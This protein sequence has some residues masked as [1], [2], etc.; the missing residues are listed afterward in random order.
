MRLQERRLSSLLSSGASASSAVNFFLS[1]AE[2]AEDAED[3][4]LGQHPGARC[5]TFVTE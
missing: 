3:F 2:D 4:K 1:T 5:K